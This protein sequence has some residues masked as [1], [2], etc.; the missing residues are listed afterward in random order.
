MNWPHTYKRRKGIVQFP[1]RAS[2]IQ[3]RLL[4]VYYSK[5][6]PARPDLYAPGCPYSKVTPYLIFTE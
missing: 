5:V 6:T 3:A 1:R 2:R 4:F